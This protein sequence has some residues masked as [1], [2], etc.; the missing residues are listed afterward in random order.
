MAETG[1]QFDRFLLQDLL[2]QD[3]W[4]E[5]YLAF[6]PKLVRQVSIHIL[7]KQL[8][9]NPQVVERYAQVARTIIRWRQ[10]GIAKLFDF[11]QSDNRVY[12]V[13]DYCPGESLAQAC[14]SLQAAGKWISL[15]EAVSL[16]LEVCQALEYAHQRN[17]THGNLIA[18]NIL[19]C[20]GP[21]TYL[22]YQPILI[23]LGLGLPGDDQVSSDP[24]RLQE[25]VA[26]DIRA[27]GRLLSFLVCGEKSLPLR[28]LRP[29]LPHSLERVIL[30]RDFHQP[31]GQF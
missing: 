17:L 7:A 18:E 15:S 27:A 9:E 29:D 11:G 12:M 14:E 5:V 8:A 24:T 30:P 22:P 4:G 3:L 19:L 6:D 28:D 23:N 21:G 1:K 16:T 26:A 10:P 20:A 31:G 13:Q 2:R 25:A